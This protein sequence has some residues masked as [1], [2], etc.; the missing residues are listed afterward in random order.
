MFLTVASDMSCNQLIF[1]MC[2]VLFEVGT[3]FLSIM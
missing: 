2:G 1:V 3:E